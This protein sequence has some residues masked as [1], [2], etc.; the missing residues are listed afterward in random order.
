MRQ[1]L[2]L[3]ALVFVLLLTFLIFP[4]SRGYAATYTGKVV[5]DE[6]VPIAGAVVVGFWPE[7]SAGL[8]GGSTRT[9]DVTETLTD[10]NGAWTIEKDRVG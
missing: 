10:S 2:Y 3:H 1:L 6:G 4:S 9:K 7:K 8:T 5:D